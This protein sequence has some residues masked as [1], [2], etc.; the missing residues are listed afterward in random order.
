MV[1]TAYHSFFGGCASV[2]GTLIGL[3]FVAISVSPHKHV[4]TNAPLAFQVQAGVAITTLLNALVIALAALLPSHNLGTAAVILAVAGLSSTI[5]MTVISLRDRPGRRRPWGL[6]IIPVLGVLYILQLHS[7]INLLQHPANPNPVH[8][9]ALLIIA[10]FMIAIARAWQMIGARDTGLM[11][12]VGNLLRERHGT[13]PTSA[14]AVPTSTIDAHTTD[15]DVATGDDSDSRPAL[16][17][18]IKP[19]AGPP[20]ASAERHTG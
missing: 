9:Q 7:G 1:P 17:A 15:L 3:L 12:V 19:A 10:F 14:E 20:L 13:P 4:G 16:S 18:R 6:A 11:A 5:G 2:A 8:F